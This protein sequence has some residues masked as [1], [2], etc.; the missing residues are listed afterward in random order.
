MQEKKP[1]PLKF[2]IFQL[3]L[4]LLGLR[5]LTHCLVEIV[6]VHCISIILDSK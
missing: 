3:A 4:K 2:L 6:L 5:H 1:L